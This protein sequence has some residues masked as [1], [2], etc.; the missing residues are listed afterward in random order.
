MSTHQSFNRHRRLTRHG[1]LAALV[2]GSVAALAACGQDAEGGEVTLRIGHTQGDA[3]PYQACGIEHLQS[4]LE[5]SGTG[6]SV[7]A[8]PNAQL[9]SNEDNLTAIQGGELDGAIPGVGSL[10]IFDQRV[11]VLEL[12]F[13][14]DSLNDVQQVMDSELGQEIFEPLRESANVRVLG[15]LWPLGTRHVTANVPVTSPQDLQGLKLRSQDT[16]S[17]RA[18]VEALG[19]SANPINFT[20]LYL[21]LSQG[22]V[23]G[24]ENPLNQ[25]DFGKFQEVQEHLSLTGHVQNAST[26][27]VSESSYSSLTAEQ[28][29]ALDSA[30]NGA[31]E[32][33]AACIADIDDE[34]LEEWRV[35]DVIE[36][37]DAEQIDRA[38]FREQARQVYSDP[39]YADIGGD[40]YDDV[41]S[42]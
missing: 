34:L 15:P 27:V 36:I 6:V 20:E 24:Q 9:G 2:A 17:S 8:F 3:H 28:Q 26:L 38:A 14:Y 12:A 35:T 18:T 30:A 1:V 4:E 10:S 25:I 31:Q 16:P 32:A 7:Q 13:A 37:V 29:D 23:D 21:A 22:V 5:A 40:L 42:D 11:G 19:A 39:Q 41:A 33:V